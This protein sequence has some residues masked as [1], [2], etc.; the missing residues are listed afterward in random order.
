[1]N[2]EISVIMMVL[3]FRHVKQNRT[4]VHYKSIQQE[5]VSMLPPY[6]SLTVLGQT[7]RSLYQSYWHGADVLAV[8]QLL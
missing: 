6:S 8:L 5:L 7:F 2:G 1:M 4:Y 3:K